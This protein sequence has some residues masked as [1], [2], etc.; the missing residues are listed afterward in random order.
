MKI[1]CCCVPRS[2]LR[3]VLRGGGQGGGDAGLGAGLFE[4]EGGEGPSLASSSSRARRGCSGPMVSWPRRRASRKVSSRALRAPASNGI[5]SGMSPAGS[6]SAAVRAWRKALR[7]RPWATIAAAAGSR[8]ESG[9]RGRGA[10]GRSRGCR[11]R[12]L[13]LRPE[14]PSGPLA[15]KRCCAA[16]LSPPCSGRSRSTRRQ[17]G[18][19]GRRPLG[20]NSVLT[21][22][23]PKDRAPVGTCA[24]GRPCAARGTRAPRGPADRDGPIRT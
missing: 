23:A 9:G 13:L 16:C 3:P 24:G 10:P 2:A 18:G 4:A 1:V 7:V 8:A 21:T 22:S 11:R 17:S 20:V 19:P 6:G 14:G 5:R 12:G 15:T